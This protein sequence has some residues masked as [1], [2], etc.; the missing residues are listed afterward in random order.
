MYIYNPV[1][2][3]ISELVA[4]RQKYRCQVDGSDEFQGEKLPIG[5]K[6]EVLSWIK[7]RFKLVDEF[8]FVDGVEFSEAEAQPISQLIYFCCNPL[9]LQSKSLPPKPSVLRYRVDV[10]GAE[11]IF[12]LNPIPERFL[13]YYPPKQLIM[14]T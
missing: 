8:G 11:K 3:F 6:E 13:E 12:I 5:T 10:G 2:D 14:G 7:D 9:A 4:S 1:A